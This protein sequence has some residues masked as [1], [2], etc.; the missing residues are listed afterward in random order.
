MKDRFFSPPGLLY[1]YSEMSIRA[2]SGSLY[3]SQQSMKPYSLCK[4]LLLPWKP[5]LWAECEALEAP[6][7]IGLAKTS[8]KVSMR[9]SETRRESVCR[10]GALHLQPLFAA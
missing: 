2:I 1:R 7:G 8:P 4:V 5:R 10:S 9:G 3:T 6:R